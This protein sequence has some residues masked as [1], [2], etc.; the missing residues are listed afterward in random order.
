MSQAE[1]PDHRDR[2]ARVL[3]EHREEIERLAR[4][5]TEFAKRAESALEWLA[6]YTEEDT[7]EN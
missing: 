7:D 2:I 4:T 3:E 5:D 1:R 6:E